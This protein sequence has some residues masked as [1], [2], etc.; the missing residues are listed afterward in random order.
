LRSGEF[1]SKGKFLLSGEYFVLYGAKALAVPLKFGQ[2]MIVSEIPRPGMIDWETYIKD[3]LWFTASYRLNDLAIL[4]SADQNTAVF[5]RDLL[6]EG[7]ILQPELQTATYGFS[8]KNHVDFDILWGL[9]SSSSLVSNLA[10]WLDV[11]PYHLYRSTFQGSGYDVFCARANGPLT[12][13]LNHDCCEIHEVPFK[14]AFSDHL[15]FIYL[16][17][18]QDS[19]ESVRKFKAQ[20]L[21]D[22]KIIRQVS[23]LTDALINSSDFEEFSSVMRVHEDVISAAIGL[24]AVKQEFF[25]DFKGEIKSLGAWG[26]DFVM[27]ATSLHEEEVKDYFYKKNLQVVFRWEEIIF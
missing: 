20:K 24:P 2:K 16:G 13:Q 9:G 6:K 10:Y 11:D 21:N 18:K 15:F 5:V 4:D 7:G 17:L 27:A 3:K 8:I 22:D 19:Q 1:Y 14:P 23:D 26:G 25:P 12:F